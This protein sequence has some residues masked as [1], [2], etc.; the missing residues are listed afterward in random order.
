VGFKDFLK[1]MPSMMI[2]LMHKI[3]IVYFFI[4]VRLFLKGD[5]PKPPLFFYGG[6]PFNPPPALCPN[7]ITAPKNYTLTCASNSPIKPTL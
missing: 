2:T 6:R 5:H 3:S 1:I 4:L 7:K